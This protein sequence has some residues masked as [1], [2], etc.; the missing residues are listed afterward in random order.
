MAMSWKKGVGPAHVR[1][2]DVPVQASEDE[3]AVAADEEDLIAL[4]FRVAAKI[5]SIVYIY[6]KSENRLYLL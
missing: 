6:H 3:G 1:L 4:R 5:T 2:G